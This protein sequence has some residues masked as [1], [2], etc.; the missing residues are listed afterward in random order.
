MVVGLVLLKPVYLD[1][2]ALTKG[3]ITEPLQVVNIKDVNIEVNLR[4]KSDQLEDTQEASLE[5]DQET[6]VSMRLP[7]SDSLVD[8]QTVSDMPDQS[9]AAD[10]TIER[11]AEKLESKVGQD[12]LIGPPCDK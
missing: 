10:F 4:A 1:D 2:V 12:V 9:V 8:G 3:T 6:S 7:V 11:D 5:Q